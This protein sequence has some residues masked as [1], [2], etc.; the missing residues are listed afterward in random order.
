MGLHSPVLKQR[1]EPYNGDKIQMPRPENRNADQ[2]TNRQTK[3]RLPIL[4]QSGK[5]NQHFFHQRRNG[6][7]K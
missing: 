3:F 4:P 7:L 5:Q 6:S 2:V 1:S